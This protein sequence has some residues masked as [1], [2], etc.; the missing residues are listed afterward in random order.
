MFNPKKRTNKPRDAFE[1]TAFEQ[2]FE[3]VKGRREAC[4]H[5]FVTDTTNRFLASK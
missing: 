1:N 4:L 5:V 2:W 3:N